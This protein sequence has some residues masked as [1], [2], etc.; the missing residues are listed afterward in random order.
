MKKKIISIAAFILI[1]FVDLYSQNEQDI[2]TLSI[3][4]EYVKSKDYD[5]AYQPWMELRQRN[6]KFNKA[7]FIYGELILKHKVKTSVGQDQINFLNDLLK[8]WKERK[9]HFDGSTPTGTYMAKSCQLKYDYRNELGY[10]KQNILECF[11]ESYELDSE[12]FTNPKSL[13]TYFSLVVDIYDLGEIQANELFNMYDIITEKVENEIKNYTNKRN[14]YLDENGDVKELSSKDKSKLKSYNS[15]LTAYEKISGSI[16]SKLGSRANCENLIPLY[17]KDFDKNKDNG[18]W[19]QRAMNRMYSKGCNEDPLFIKI[20]EEKNKLEPN[21]DTSFYLG[22]LKEK[23]GLGN[24]AVV[25]YNQAIDLETDNFAKSKILFK[26]ATSFKNRHR[27]GQARKYYNKALKYNPSMGRAY[28]A[29]AA[30]YAKSANKCGSD[31]FSKR[32]VYWL[33]ANEAAKASRVDP[34]MKKYANKS[35]RN[36]KE[37]APQKNEIFSSGRAGERISIGCW[38][39][40]SITVPKL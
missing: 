10:T 24:E 30:M 38:I 9:N 27:Y 3:F 28:L 21:A 2:Q 26:I 5:A 19:L 6:P 22:L 33:A 4:T 37:K 16:D 18:L 39:N 34:S 12:S 20:V 14:L 11:N 23:A 36:Y 25:Y 32:A 35:I 7:I 31:N 1:T 40:K 13:Y 8:L 29:I 15:Y 17:K